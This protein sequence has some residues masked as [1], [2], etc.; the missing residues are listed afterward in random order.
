MA[1]KKG[2][3]KKDQ[4]SKENTE[5]CV[6]KSEKAAHWRAFGMMLLIF[7]AATAY[8]FYNKANLP[9]GLEYRNG[10]EELMSTYPNSS[11]FVIGILIGLFSSLMMKFFLD[12]ENLKRLKKKQKELQ[13]E[14]KECQKNGDT[15]KME[16]LNTEMMQLSTEMMKASFS[17]KQFLV[18]FVPFLVLFA[19]LRRVYVDPSG[20][21]TNGG[22]I[23]RYMIAV[24]VSSSLYKK[25]FDLA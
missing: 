4:S 3:S 24:L 16:N 20:I 8:D 22:F 5:A 23:L 7:L 1:K 6:V 11:I 17:L 12:Q 18:T 2:D 14:L 10:L 25:L 9:E 21:F 15:K 13:C 19:W